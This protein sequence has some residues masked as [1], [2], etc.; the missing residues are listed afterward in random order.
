[1]KVKERERERERGCRMINTTFW[2]KYRIEQG[3]CGLFGI[4]ALEV[5]RLVGVQA[6][7]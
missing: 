5:E 3:G 1:M 2:R 6:M 4:T 7:H